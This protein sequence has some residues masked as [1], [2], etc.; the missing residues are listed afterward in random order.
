MQPDLP[1]IGPGLGVHVV[2]LGAG[3]HAHQSR[4]TDNGM[5]GWFQVLDGDEPE[6]NLGAIGGLYQDEFADCTP[7][8]G[9]IG[10]KALLK[11]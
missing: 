1:A 7:C 2:H 6:S 11:Y 10:A 5:S 8:L 9:Q 4:L 3:A